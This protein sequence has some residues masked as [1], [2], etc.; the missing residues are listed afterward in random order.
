[1]M[2]PGGSDLVVHFPY[3]LQGHDRGGVPNQRAPGS[4][5]VSRC[6]ADRLPQSI[7]TYSIGKFGIESKADLRALLH[8]F[9]IFE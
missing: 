2:H 8:P 9:E 1:M 6:F 7:Y 5:G 4:V 3:F